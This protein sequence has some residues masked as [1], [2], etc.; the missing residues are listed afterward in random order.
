MLDFVVSSLQINALLS[1]VGLVLL[2]VDR[3]VVEDCS[4]EKLDSNPIITDTVSVELMKNR[5][6]EVYQKA[7]EYHRSQ[8]FKM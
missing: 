8:E 2:P 4:C 6:V 5:K 1:F 3:W 7:N